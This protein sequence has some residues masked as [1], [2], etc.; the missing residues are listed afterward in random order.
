MTVAQRWSPFPIRGYL[1]AG[2]MTKPYPT[3]VIVEPLPTVGA[4]RAWLAL[5]PSSLVI[6]RHPDEAISKLAET[7]DLSGPAVLRFPCGG[8]ACLS[9]L[10]RGE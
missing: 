1:Q 4:W 9:A 8:R 6:A 2:N 3:H 10:V 7:F 5:A